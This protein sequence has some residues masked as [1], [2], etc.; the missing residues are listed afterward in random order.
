M[1]EDM[2]EA[3]M[4]RRWPGVSLGGVCRPMQDPSRPYDTMT[5]IIHTIP[6]HPRLLSPGVLRIALVGEGRGEVR[7]PIS[8]Q[9]CLSGLVF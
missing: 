9:L 1:A 2:R 6:R 5:D 8:A 7:R 4:G 3:A